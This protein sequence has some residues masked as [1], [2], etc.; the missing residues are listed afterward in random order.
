MTEYLYHSP[1]DEYVAFQEFYGI[2][3][4]FDEDVIKKFIWLL[5]RKLTA[6]EKVSVLIIIIPGFRFR[7][8]NLLN[9][10]YDG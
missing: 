10:Y 3:V 8:N 5:L 4:H 2:F 1:F 7:M 6:Q 9:G